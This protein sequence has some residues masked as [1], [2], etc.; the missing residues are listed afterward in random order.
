[1]ITFLI[2]NIVISCHLFCQMLT[3]IFLKQTILLGYVELQLFC[4]YNL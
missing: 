1:M 2:I 4:G 3:I